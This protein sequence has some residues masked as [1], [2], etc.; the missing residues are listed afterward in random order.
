MP[1]ELDTHKLKV[2]QMVSHEC[3]VKINLEDSIDI[4]LNWHNEKF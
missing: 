1:N 3:P 2:L 4:R